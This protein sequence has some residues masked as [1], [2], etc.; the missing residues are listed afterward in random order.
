MIINKT[1]ALIHVANPRRGNG[2]FAEM[3]AGGG[4]ISERGSEL[5]GLGLRRLVVTLSAVL[6][7][8][9]VGNSEASVAMLQVTEAPHW[10]QNLAS[11]NKSAPQP[12][13][14]ETL[15]TSIKIR[16]T[17]LFGKHLRCYHH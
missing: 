17:F 4:G 15:M 11:G 10:R 3:L 6:F 9:A 2:I 14:W 8:V 12:G 1:A 13:H 7:R 16:R 5:V